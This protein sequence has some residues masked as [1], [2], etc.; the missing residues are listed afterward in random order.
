MRIKKKDEEYFYRMLKK[1][2]FY[3]MLE[4]IKAVQRVSAESA[5]LSLNKDFKTGSN[6]DVT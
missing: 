6:K 4:L 5:Y 1:L 3:E 2:S